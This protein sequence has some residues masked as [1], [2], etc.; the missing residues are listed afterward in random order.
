MA[1]KIDR[2]IEIL[3][4]VKLLAKEYYDLTGRP[5]GVTGEV[6]EYEAVRLLG[7][8][9]SPVRQ[10]GFDALRRIAGRTERIQIKGRC[11]PV[12]AKR[13]QRISRIDLAKEFDAV[14]LV[15][16]NEDLEATEIYEATQ[17]QVSEAL[18]APGS[19]SRN[20]RGALGVSTFKRIGRR[21]WPA[22]A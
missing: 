11:I 13:G 2:M 19:R 7:L 1:E 22:P 20:E 4:Q 8:E 18:L 5:L 15:L 17:Q 14:V 12:G 16:L 10:P 6:A 3:R 21:I 9:I